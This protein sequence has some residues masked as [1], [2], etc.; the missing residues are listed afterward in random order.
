LLKCCPARSFKRYVPIS[1]RRLDHCAVLVVLLSVA[2][3]CSRAQ[4]T[5]ATPAAPAAPAAPVDHVLMVSVDGLL[6]ASYLEPDAH[7][8]AVPTLRLL[9]RTGAAARGA[10]SVFPSVT[11]PSHTTMAT[12]V[13]PA[14]HG[15]VTNVAADPDERNMDGWRWYTEDIKV[16]TLWDVATAAGRDVALVNWPVTVGARVRW[17]VPE[18]WRAG[19]PEDAKLTR[20]LA[21]PGL[22]PAVA[23]R[24]PNL[25]QRFTPPNVADEATADIVIHLISSAPVSLVMAHIWQTDDAQHRFGPWSPE[26][27]VAIE[28]AD[29]QLG[30]MVDAAKAAWPW[31]RTAVVIVSDHG[32]QP[33]TR[34]VRPGVL[35]REHGF[36]AVDEAGHPKTA[37]ATVAITSGL[38]FF[39]VAAADETTR[40]ALGTLLASLAAQP[41]SGIARVYDAKAIAARGGD[42]TA[43]FAIE[44]APG[45]AFA[46][47]YAGPREGPAGSRGQHG[48]DPDRPEM[49]AS[50]LMAGGA[51]ASRQ[52][53]GVGLVDVAPTIAQALGLALPRATGRALPVFAPPPAPAVPTATATPAATALPKPSAK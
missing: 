13:P 29:R 49:R 2:G 46:R 10:R 28:N 31:S 47:G 8:L 44:A 19:T 42:P 3:G 36:V 40:A 33:V 7:G 21:T 30:R 11:Y 25:W 50:F 23:A 4:A 37:R 17:L 1:M 20:A 15:I 51:I 34:D 14:V 38:A 43:T 12:G 16:P 35:L 9:A 5:P 53:D 24:F 39:Y 48:Y 27:R 45:V 26:A 18:Y 6:P 32:F 52:L 22:L 41:A